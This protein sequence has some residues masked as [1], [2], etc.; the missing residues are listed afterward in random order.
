MAEKCIAIVVK[1]GCGWDGLD[2][3]TER[4]ELPAAKY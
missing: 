2:F 3:G 4:S 1:D